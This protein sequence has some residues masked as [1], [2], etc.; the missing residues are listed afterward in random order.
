MGLEDHQPILN[1]VR[2]DPEYVADFKKVFNKSGDGITM[3][4]VTKAIAAFEH[5][6][7][8]LPPEGGTTF[9]APVALWLG[10][11]Y[12]ALGEARKSREW[13]TT[14]VQ[15]AHTLSLL[16]CSV[17]FYLQGKAFAALGQTSSA[18]R[19]YCAA[20]RSHVLY[21]ARLEVKS[22]LHQGQFR[23]RRFA[24][25]SNPQRPEYCTGMYA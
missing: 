4:E 23:T 3:D 15:R 9:A 12:H 8:L 24:M 1:I 17:G 2:S 14:A 6:W 25:T 16:D 7:Q 22:T 19:S 11:S 18:Y 20:F 5:G 13:W 10:D 21:P